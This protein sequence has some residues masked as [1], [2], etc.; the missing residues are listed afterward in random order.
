MSGDVREMLD[1]WSS[2]L[3]GLPYAT[4]LRHWDVD[5]TSLDLTIEDRSTANG[6]WATSALLEEGV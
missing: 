6:L 3:G 5:M 4:L 2:D 1:L